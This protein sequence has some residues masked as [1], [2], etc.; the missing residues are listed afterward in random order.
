MAVGYRPGHGFR[1]ARLTER[2]QNEPDVSD[3][4]SSMLR[5][6][7]SD[8]PDSS[9]RFL[10]SIPWLRGILDTYGDNPDFE[11]RRRS[12]RAVR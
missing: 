9:R 10:G 7:G 4:S 3:R 5:R 11:D 12:P 6:S 1:P 2:Q 8:R